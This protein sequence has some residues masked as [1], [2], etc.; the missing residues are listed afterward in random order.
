M[1]LTVLGSAGWIPEGTRET[2][3][4]AVR[5]GRSLL[6]LDAGSGT[7]RL[8]ADRAA[9]LRDV[10]EVHVVL[11]H[12]HLDH[13]VGLTYLTAVDF[14]G[15]ITIWGP[16][17]F[18]DRTSEEILNTVA[19]PPYQ[20]KV[21]GELFT[22][23][24]VPRAGLRTRDFDV[25]VRLQPLHSAPSIAMRVNDELSYCTDT[26]YDEGNTGF[27]ERCHTLVHEAWPASSGPTEGHSA[28]AEAA[29]VAARAGVRRLILGHVP[30]RADVDAM[31]AEARGVFDA[32]SVADEQ[33]V[34]EVP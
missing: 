3:C 13:V 33:M 31:L 8:A 11:S 30:P 34:L 26:A 16:G 24:D 29:R 6:L 5:S 27:V 10:D 7:G 9:L 12:F 15:E 19:G 14:D 20:P 17:A 28:P 18:Y 1:I 2:S 21:L 23:R 32:T 4:Y 22:I 25:S